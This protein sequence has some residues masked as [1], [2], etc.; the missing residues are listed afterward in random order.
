MTT[1]NGKLYKYA[2][3]STS[4]FSIAKEDL[5]VVQSIKTLQLIIAFKD[6]KNITIQEALK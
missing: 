6:G 5:K 4:D 3:G 2:Y 1:S